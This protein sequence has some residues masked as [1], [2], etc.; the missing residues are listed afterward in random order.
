MSAL[1]QIAE[2]SKNLLH[3]RG[4]PHMAPHY[5]LQFNPPVALTY[6]SH[7]LTSHSED[8]LIEVPATDRSLST[9]LNER[10]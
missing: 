3:R 9:F 1:D 8:H 7:G 4:R 5:A 6:S 2:A 10:N